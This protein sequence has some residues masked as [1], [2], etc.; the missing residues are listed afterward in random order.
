MRCFFSIIFSVITLS[1][2]SQESKKIEALKKELSNA[3]SD[4]AKLSILEDLWKLT[5]Y[6]NATDAI[7]YAEAAVDIAKTADLEKQLARAYERLGIAHA[8]ISEYTK[9]N[10]AY[11][12]AIKLHKS[13]GNTRNVG[14][15]YMNQAINFKDNAQYDSALVYMDKSEPFIDLSCCKDDSILLINLYGIKA[16][17]YTEKGDYLT[18]LDYAIGA[19]DI[20]LAVKD[21]IQYADNLALIGDNN[22]ALGNDDAAINYFTESI[23][24]YKIAEDTYYEC[25]TS[26]KIGELYATKQPIAKDSAELYLNRAIHL[27]QQIKVPFLEMQALNVYANYLLATKNDSKATEVL[28]KSLVI[29]ERL[30]DSFSLSNIKLGL[31]KLSFRSKDYNQALVQAKA[32]LR[33]KENIGLL[34]GSV[35]SNKLIADIYKAK[36]DYNNALSYQETYKKLSDSLYNVEKAAKFDQLQTQFDTQK[37]ETEIAL[38]NEEIK[39]LNAQAKNDRLTKTL[40]GVGMFSF[41]AIAALLYF[42]FKQRIKKNKIAREKQEAIYRQ[43]IEFKKK[44]LASQTLHLVQKKS[45][46][47]ELKENLERLKSSP[48]QFKIEFKRLIMLL[49]KE[50]AEDKDWEVFKSYFAEVHNDFDGKLKSF[51]DDLTEKEMRLAT[52]LRMSLTTKEIA[53]VLNVLPDSVLKSK[54]RLKKK[55]GLDKDQDLTTYLSSL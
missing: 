17:I 30:K 8:N 52:F 47:Q 31:A 23:N 35:E 18:S 10:D 1:I 28:N 49:K 27:A 54:Y 51:A 48:D 38:Q 9:S 5:A 44:E 16:Q 24:I 6:D 53:A 43:E 39:T 14:G 50:N 22:E 19:A 45:F 21:S 46:L 33:L 32:A 11:I 42:G 13:L 2:F 12:N 15:L 29:T 37:K 34:S 3:T 20:A 7:A 4:V 25:L 41:L 26:K 40:Y 36:G 55:L